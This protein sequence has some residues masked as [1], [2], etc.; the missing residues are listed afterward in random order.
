MMREWE[1]LLLVKN[2]NLMR[3]KRVRIWKK[4]QVEIRMALNKQ[5]RRIILISFLK[6]GL[7]KSKVRNNQAKKTVFLMAI[8]NKV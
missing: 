5:M 2:A 7:N 4:I 6:T 8:Q 1:V 3:E